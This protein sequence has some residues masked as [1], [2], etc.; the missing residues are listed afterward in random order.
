VSD[1]K[2]AL[3]RLNE[4]IAK[5]N[6]SPPDTAPWHAQI[7]AW[8]EGASRSATTAQ[9][10]IQPQ[11]AVQALYELTKGDAIITTGVGQH[12]M[13]AAQFYRFNEPRRYISSL[14]LGA[15]GFGYPAAL[16]AKVACPDRQVIDID[17]DGS[18]ADEHPGARHRAH[19]EDR[20]E[21]DDPE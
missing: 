4:L 19:R 1:V 20:G 10:H 5:S 12:Q 21:G 6:F 17:G 16:G 11:E 3:G 18:F 8:K 15:M 13:W 14:G 9:R 7:S 2:Y